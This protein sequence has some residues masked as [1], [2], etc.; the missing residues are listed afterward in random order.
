MNFE[1]ENSNTVQS[2]ICREMGLRLNIQSGATLT[3]ILGDFYEGS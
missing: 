1:K 3:G 2:L